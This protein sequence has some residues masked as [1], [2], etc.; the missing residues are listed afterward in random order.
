MYPKNI[1]NENTTVLPIEEVFEPVIWH[2]LSYYING[3]VD[4][5]NESKLNDTP[6][7]DGSEDEL[8]DVF[9]SPDVLGQPFYDPRISPFDVAEV[10]GVETYNEAVSVAQ[11]PTVTAPTS[12]LSETE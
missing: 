11:T 2:P 8:P 4:I 12:T 10:I 5:S 3:G 7:Y 1:I 9:T 6:E